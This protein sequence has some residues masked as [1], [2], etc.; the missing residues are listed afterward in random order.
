MAFANS[1]L[2]TID[3]FYNYSGSLPNIKIK[4]TIYNGSSTN[5]PNTSILD[6]DQKDTCAELSPC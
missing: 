1:E 3:K 5:G 4:I 2:L 6:A